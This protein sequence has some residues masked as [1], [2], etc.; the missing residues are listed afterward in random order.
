MT[1]ETV[2]RAGEHGAWYQ[3]AGGRADR[4]WTWLDLEEIADATATRAGLGHAVLFDA[5]QV[6]GGAGGGGVV[7]AG[8][9][10]LLPA[11]RPAA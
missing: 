10:P 4:A 5:V 11:A 9:R 7:R 2:A 1:L 6:R 3:P 8:A